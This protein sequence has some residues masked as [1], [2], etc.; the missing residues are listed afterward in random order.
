MKFFKKIGDYVLTKSNSFKYYKNNL[1][2]TKT[3]LDELIKQHETDSLKI[4]ELNRK[5]Y[6][7]RND[8]SNLKN[9]NSNL[10][11]ENKE[12]I[13]EKSKKE[14]T[15]KNIKEDK[16]ELTNE[17]KNREETISLLRDQ[18]DKFNDSEN[19]YYKS[20][21]HFEIEKIEKN[22][23]EL[24]NMQISENDSFGQNKKIFKN[25]NQIINTLNDVSENVKNNENNYKMLQNLPY[26]SNEITINYWNNEDVFENTFGKTSIRLSEKEILTLNEIIEK[27]FWNRKQ[28]QK[29][30]SKYEKLKN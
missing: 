10:K 28:H 7:L 8:N 24:V 27:L 29:F 1:E 18:I 23:F 16:Q 21:L 4:Q 26:L 11:K 30:K 9:D 15:I 6:N 5:N 14:N 25:Q 19:E 17:L 3:Q 2:N 22:L 13:K 12:L 20:L